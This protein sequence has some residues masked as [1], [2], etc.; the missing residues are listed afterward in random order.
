MS[1]LKWEEMAEKK[2]KVG[3]EVLNVREMLKRN[4]IGEQV[5]DVQAEKLFKPVVSVLKELQTE[6]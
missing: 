6:P 5:K 1:L 3:R 2:S 4:K